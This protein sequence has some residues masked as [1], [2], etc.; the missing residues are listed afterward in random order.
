MNGA[1][2]CHEKN[3][4]FSVISISISIYQLMLWI[5][6]GFSAN[7]DL[8]FYLSAHPDPCIQTNADPDP[9]QT[10]EVTQS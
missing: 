10:L 2:I 8:A 3:L 9:G 7:L 5:L 6:I 1:N 4:V